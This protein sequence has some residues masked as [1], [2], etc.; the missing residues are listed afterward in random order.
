MASRQSRII[1]NTDAKN[2]ADD[3]FAIVHAL[4]SPTLKV[5]GLIA[6]HFGERRSD[7]SMEESREEIDRLLE[8][9]HLTGDV[10]V[11]NGAASKMPDETTP[12]PSPGADLIVAESLREDAGP[13]YIAFLGPL[14]DMA[15]A[16]IADPSIQDRDVT[17]VWI[18]GPAY[19]GI[20][21]GEQIEFNLSNDIDSANVV[22]ASRV[23]LWQIPRSVYTLVGVGYAELEEKVRPQ[24]KLGDY[25][26]SQ[27]IAWNEKWN[28]TPIE[29]RSLG[30]SPAIG[31]VLNPNGAVWRER[32]APRYAADGSMSDTRNA[33]IIRVCESID[34]RYLLEDMFSKLRAF[35]THE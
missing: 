12:M 32:P 8:L 3:Q 15:A 33:R 34:T 27:L 26:V 2:E 10:V 21:N 22:L 30:D 14:T 20:Y 17:V 16:L 6:A 13:L 25:L 28:P 9:M 19:D 18:G 35:A 31:V 29:H 7:R 5:E 23:K 1:I 24:G 11:A 4:L